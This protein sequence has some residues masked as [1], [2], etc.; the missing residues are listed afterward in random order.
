[1]LLT[2]M[3]SYSKFLKGGGRSPSV[4]ATSLTLRSRSPTVVSPTLTPLRT[5][6]L[7]FLCWKDLM[8]LTGMT[9]APPHSWSW[10]MDLDK[11][12]KGVLAGA[13]SLLSLLSLSRNF[14]LRQ[15]T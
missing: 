4:L 6:P 11:S 13:S 8:S 12:D 15:R 5:I 14:F 10:S 9:A 3:A 7:E 1:M 2:L